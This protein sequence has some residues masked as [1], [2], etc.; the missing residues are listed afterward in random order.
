MSSWGI[1]GFVTST[2]ISII[3]VVVSIIISLSSRRKFEL[4][5]AERDSMMRWYAETADCLMA[6][7]YGISSRD[8]FD[9][10]PQI[11]RLSSLI[12]QGR[13]FFPNKPTGQGKDKPSAYQGTRDLALDTLVFYLEICQMPD[14][15]SKIPY[16]ENL[17]RAFTSRVFDAEDPRGYNRQAC[18]STYLKPWSD[19]SKALQEFL[20]IDPSSNGFW[21]RY[22][23]NPP[24][25]GKAGAPAA[26]NSAIKRPLTRKTAKKHEIGR[27]KKHD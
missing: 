12:E 6:L 3:A 8:G 21:D 14:A 7:R 20:E 15:N 5:H 4:T 25:P 22:G 19:D 13:F 17:E 24:I 11:A 18:K 9:K 23:E 26:N 27:P 10:T 16:L 2:V 1:A